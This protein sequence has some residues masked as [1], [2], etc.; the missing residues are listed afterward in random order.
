MSKRGRRRSSKRRKSSSSS[1][2]THSCALN[3]GLKRFTLET[4]ECACV[5]VCTRALLLIFDLDS[6]LYV[7][8]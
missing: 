4:L 2:F 8:I 7:Y 5:F 1:K 3:V 6:Y